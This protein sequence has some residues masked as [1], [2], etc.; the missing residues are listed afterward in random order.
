[1]LSFV[2]L[3]DDKGKPI[4][5]L[6]FSVP[7]RS[8]APA[9]THGHFA[10]LDRDVTVEIWKP[11]TIFENFLPMGNMYTA[12]ERPLLAMGIGTSWLA[13]ETEEDIVIVLNFTLELL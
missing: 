5:Q 11:P 13:A 8:V 1:M 6:G 3:V 10:V 12:L 7:I 2:D 4:Q 9:S